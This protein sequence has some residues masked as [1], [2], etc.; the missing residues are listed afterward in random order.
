ML[1]LVL[2]NKQRLIVENSG[3]MALVVL[4]ALLQPFC[5]LEPVIEVT[6]SRF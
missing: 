4:V 3:V 1:A 2:K 5:L 6:G